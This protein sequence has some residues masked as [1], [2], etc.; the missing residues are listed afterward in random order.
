MSWKV[1]KHATVSRSSAEVKYRSMSSFVYE[2]SWLKDLINKLR[3]VD[4]LPANLYCDNKAAIQIATNRMYHEWTKHIEIDCH[5]F[6]RL[7]KC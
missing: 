5:F 2:I 3:I 4:S 6:K 7:N 1:K